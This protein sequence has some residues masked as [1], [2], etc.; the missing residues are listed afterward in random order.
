[1]CAQCKGACHNVLRH[2]GLSTFEHQVGKN[3]QVET[4][5]IKGAEDCSRWTGLEAQQDLTDRTS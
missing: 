2:A 1:M 5:K 4:D 3:S